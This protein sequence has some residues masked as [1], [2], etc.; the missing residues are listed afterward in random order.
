ML[1]LF[2]GFGIERVVN[3][4]VRVSAPPSGSESDTSIDAIAYISH[5]VILD[6]VSEQCAIPT[7]SL[8]VRLAESQIFGMRLHWPALNPKS[9]HAAARQVYS[10]SFQTRH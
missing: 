7:L 2:E 4:V 5:Q 10:E 1:P 9:I 8:L 3:V 6:Y